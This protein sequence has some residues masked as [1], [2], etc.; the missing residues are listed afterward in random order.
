MKCKIS[1]IKRKGNEIA[2]HLQKVRPQG[3]AELRPEWHGKGFGLD[4]EK[5]RWS[6]HKFSSRGAAW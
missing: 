1:R 5:E 6:H 4:S 2:L 3:S